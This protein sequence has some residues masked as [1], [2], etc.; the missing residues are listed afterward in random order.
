MLA[1]G[2]LLT[3]NYLRTAPSNPGVMV[4]WRMIG[5]NLNS[6]SGSPIGW[7]VSGIGIILT[8]LGV[9]YLIR[10]RFQ[11][12]S[13]EWMMMLGVFTATIAV[14]WHSHYHLAMVLIPLIITTNIAKKTTD[15]VMY[16][17]VTLTPTIWL[18]YLVTASI[19]ASSGGINIGE[20]QGIV[21]G[22]TG[23]VV[24]IILFAET[25]RYFVATN[26]AIEQNN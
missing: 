21:I 20:Y 12:G 13:Q 25:I 26:K 7:L 19:L 11:F 22:L 14:S 2:R 17:W 1:L 8:I 18:F 23:F 16:F 9:Y 3:G 6:V 15:K 4:N 24:N 10:H 5:V